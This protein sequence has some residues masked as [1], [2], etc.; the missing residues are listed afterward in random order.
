[1]KKGDIVTVYLD[2]L[3]EK[4]PEGQAQLLERLDTKGKYRSREYW[5]VKFLNGGDIVARFVCSKDTLKRVQKHLTTKGG[6]KP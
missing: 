3:T 5:Q 4:S 1:M 6:I 2:P